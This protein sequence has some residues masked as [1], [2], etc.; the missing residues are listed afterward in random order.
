MMLSF[1]EAREALGVKLGGPNQVSAAKTEFF[2]PTS[3]M[4][5]TL[6]GVTIDDQRTSDRRR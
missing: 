3:N 6:H 5:A 4:W 2:E 1:A